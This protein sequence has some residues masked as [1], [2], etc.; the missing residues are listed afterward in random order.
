M[1]HRIEQRE[2]TYGSFGGAADT[3]MR[4]FR[5]PAFP[6]AFIIYTPVI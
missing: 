4:K 1:L 5:N 3:R 6:E 2:A